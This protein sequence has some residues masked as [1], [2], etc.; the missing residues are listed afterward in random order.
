[1]QNSKTLISIIM[2]VYNGATYLAESIESIIRQ[3]FTQWELI[4]IDDGSG[5]TSRLIAAEYETRDIRIRSIINT[6]QKGLAGALN[7]GLAH[8]RG[9]YIAR[10]DADDINVPQRLEI[11]YTYLQNHPEVAIVGSWYKTFGTNKKS[12]VRTHPSQ[13]VVIAWKY[14]TDTYLCHPTTLFRKSV[15]D[16]VPTYPLVASED[17][18]F[19]SEVI[20]TYRGYNIPRVLLNY[21]EHAKNYSTTEAGPIKESVFETYTKNYTYYGG[22]PNLRNEFYQFHAH[23]RISLKVFFSILKQSFKIGRKILEQYALQKNAPAFL[24]L[25]TTLIIHLGIAIGNSTVRTL[26]KK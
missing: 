23:Y 10:A 21:R 4:I 6:S 12:R 8:A 7:T 20:H 24:C 16:R 25:Y 1:M 2:P 3:T 18:A 15:L 22:A 9:E 13:G 14:L 26:F 11:E 17:F 19:F 5:D